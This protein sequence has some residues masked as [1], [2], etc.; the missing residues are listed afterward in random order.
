MA[1]DGVIARAVA[2][3]AIEE[4]TA[5]L[6][7]RPA[8][9]LPFSEQERSYALSKPDPERRLAARLAAKRAATAALGGGVQEE[10][11]EVAPARGGPPGLILAPRAAA[12]AAELGMSRALV[13]LTH[14]LT[15]AAAVVLLVD[16][17]R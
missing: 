8:S 15:H 6:R 12:R 10:D 14:G 9:D 11:V 1:S 17:K 2:V 16:E 3:V 13:S 5:L 7:E 4:M